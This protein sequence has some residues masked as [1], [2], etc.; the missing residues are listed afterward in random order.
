[1][2]EIL[3]GTNDTKIDVTHIAYNNFV[4]GSTQ[5]VCIPRNDNERAKL[6][7]D[8]KY[9]TVKTVFITSNDITTEYDHT[10]HIYIDT[11]NE[12]VYTTDNAV[13][14]TIRPNEDAYVCG[15]N[16]H[17]GRRMKM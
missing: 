9:G 17:I 11:T 4:Y 12:D 1:M 16:G 10:K 6:F 14:L 15:H 5:Y 8:P 3:Y 2:L 7:T 13:D